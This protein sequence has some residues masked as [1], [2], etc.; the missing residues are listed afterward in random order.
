[1]I[2]LA[3]LIGKR[4][5]HSAKSKKDYVKLWFDATP[6]IDGLYGSACESI[7]VED[8]GTSFEV[9]K[10]YTISVDSFGRLQDVQ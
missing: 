1:M 9:G 10:D 2:T 5:F 6:F 8:R 4:E 7:L 3:T